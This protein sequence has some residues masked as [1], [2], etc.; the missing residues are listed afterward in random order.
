MQKLIEEDLNNNEIT[1]QNSIIEGFNSVKETDYEKENL[2][3]EKSDKPEKL[4]NKNKN[5]SPIME[6]K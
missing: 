5:L 1:N 4:Y 6:T 3:T 2:L